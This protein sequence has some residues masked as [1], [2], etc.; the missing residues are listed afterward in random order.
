MKSLVRYLYIVAH[1]ID[2]NGLGVLCTV[3]F[4]APIIG[5]LR[6]GQVAREIIRRCGACF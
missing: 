3:V 5:I 1:S 2:P 6:V 4:A